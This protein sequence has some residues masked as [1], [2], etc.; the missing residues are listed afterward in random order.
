M[1]FTCHAMPCPFNSHM[2]CRAPVILRRCHVLR[3]SLRGSRK[4]PNCWSYS[5]TG[6]YASNNNLRGTP[7]GSRKNP[8]AGRSLTCLLWTADANS[9]MPCHAH[10]A[11]IPH[12]G[13]ELRSRFQNDT[14]VAW[15]GRGMASVNQTRP[16]CVNQTG[17]TRSKPLAVP[18][19]RGT[20]WAR[21]GKG[22]GAVWDWHGMY[23]LTFKVIR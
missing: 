11:P 6:W 13:V 21:N 10:A 12:C 23:E 8:N 5:L 22:M 18:H 1:P 9:H 7:R 19:C 20:A 16:H 14:V 15:H 4:Y 17:K 3:E 2:P